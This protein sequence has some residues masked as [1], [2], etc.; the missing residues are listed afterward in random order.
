LQVCLL[1]VV[2]AAGLEIFQNFKS[3]RRARVNDLVNGFPPIV[4]G[5][6]ASAVAALTGATES[7]EEAEA[8]DSAMGDWYVAVL[9]R[10]ILHMGGEHNW[11]K[12][13][14]INHLYRFLQNNFRSRRQASHAA[15]TLQVGMLYEF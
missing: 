11:F 14:V 12:R 7:A 15:K 10:T 6:V 5:F 2:G 9:G 4:R 13:F 8:M 3:T 1:G